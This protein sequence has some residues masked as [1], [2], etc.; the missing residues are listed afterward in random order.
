MCFHIFGDQNFLDEG[1]IDKDLNFP[2]LFFLVTFDEVRA[3]DV[4][5]LG[6]FPD[7]FLLNFKFDLNQFFKGVGDDNRFV[8]V[9][10]EFYN[11][12]F[13]FFDLDGNLG[14]NFNCVLIFDDDGNC[15]LYFNQLSFG[16]D[17]RNSNFDGFDYL[18]GL[19]LRDNFFNSFNNF[20]QF[21]HFGLNYSLYLFDFNVSDDFVDLDFPCY[22]FSFHE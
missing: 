3:V 17:V 19:Y 13:R 7:E 15:L 8:S 6:H 10:G 14:D 11:L 1:F 22:F 12:N 4:D 2:Y 21:L 9:L 20:N 5:L 16:D 18:L